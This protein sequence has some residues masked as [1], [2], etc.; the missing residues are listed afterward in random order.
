MRVHSL[1]L[2]AFGPFADRVDVDLDDVGRDGLFLLWGPTGAGKTTLLDGVVYALYGT[3]PGARGEERRLRSD[4]AADVVRT[5]VSCEVSLGGERLRGRSDLD[6]AGEFVR[7]VRGVPAGAAERA[8]LGR[9][10]GAA[11]REEAAR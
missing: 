8:L 2:T 11:D 9:A 5:V 10:L 7:H 1:S 3:V 4:H 6:V